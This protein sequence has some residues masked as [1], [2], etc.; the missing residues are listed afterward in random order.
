MVDSADHPNG[1][2]AETSTTSSGTS[3]PPGTIRLPDQPY[4]P[5][6]ANDGADLDEANGI[7]ELPTLSEDSSNASTDG[8]PAPG[9]YFADVGTVPVAPTIDHIYPLS[10][11]TVLYSPEGS[12]FLVLAEGLCLAILGLS[13]VI[14]YFLLTGRQRHPL[15]A[16]LSIFGGVVICIVI[17]AL[18]YAVVR[19]LLRRRSTSLRESSGSDH[20]QP[21][22]SNK[23]SSAV[24]AAGRGGADESRSRN[25]LLILQYHNITKKQAQSSYRNSQIAMMTGL[26][27]LIAGGIATVAA[28]TSARYVIGGLAALGT[29]LSGY[30][31]ATFIRAYS[32]AQAQMNYHY[33]QPLVTSYLLE[34]ER[35]TNSVTGARGEQIMQTVIEATLRGASDAARALTP[36]EP[37]RLRKRP[38]QE[39]DGATFR[40]S[41]SRAPTAEP[42]PS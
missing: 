38:A 22:I 23:S 11:S 10:F 30:L 16:T 20:N 18:Y 5:P 19:P 9:Q 8:T 26:L 27:L 36:L 33:G 12:I 7:S 41:G 4:P 39:R 21:N 6:G 31:G 34:A 42:G 17:L 13:V 24:A 40:G 29:A 37:A 3:S 32:I 28:P 15:G 35:M 14:A 25:Q 2:A 1:P